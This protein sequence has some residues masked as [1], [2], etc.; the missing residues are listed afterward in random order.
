LGQVVHLNSILGNFKQLYSLLV[1]F[2]Q[3]HSNLGN[4]QVETFG[5]IPTTSIIFGNSNSFIQTWVQLEPSGQIGRVSFR[6]AYIRNIWANMKF[7][8]TETTL[9]KFA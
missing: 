8:T 7:G 5:K 2:K 6:F 3:L 9:F 1:N 4:I